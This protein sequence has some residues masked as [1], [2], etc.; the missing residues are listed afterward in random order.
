MSAVDGVWA[1][2]SIRREARRPLSPV[3]VPSEPSKL[4]LNPW[5]D[6]CPISP[7]LPYPLYLLSHPLLLRFVSTFLASARYLSC[8]YLPEG[9][10]SPFSHS[11]LL[12]FSLRKQLSTEMDRYRIVRDY[13][14][15]QNLQRTLSMP[16]PIV[17]QVAV[18]S[19]ISQPT[20]SSVSSVLPHAVV[21]PH[22]EYQEGRTV[23]LFAVRIVVLDFIYS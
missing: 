18:S 7:Q 16:S 23:V 19:P 21:Q 11:L 13:D 15:L 2:D 1:F 17:S 5:L 20:V 9:I 12:L 10:C 22:V 4:F 6:L 3:F 14:F 8:L